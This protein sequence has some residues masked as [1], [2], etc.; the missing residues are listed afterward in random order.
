MKGSGLGPI[1]PA[2]Y[3]IAGD[4]A[5]YANDFFDITVG[6]NQASQDIPGYPATPGWDPTTGLG[7]PNAA[8]LIPDLV[9]ATR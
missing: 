1:N 6:D 8:K 9:A 5:K 2:L 3:S 7:T 4:P